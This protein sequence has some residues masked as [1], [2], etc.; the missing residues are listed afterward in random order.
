MILYDH[1]SENCPPDVLCKIKAALTEKEIAA[2]E[3]LAMYCYKW[4]CWRRCNEKCP[5]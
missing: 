3:Y 2:A 4:S 5:W 1:M